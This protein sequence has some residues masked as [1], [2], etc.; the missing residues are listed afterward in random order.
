VS[1]SESALDLHDVLLGAFDTRAKTAL[2][3]QAVYEVTDGSMEVRDGGGGAQLGLGDRRPSPS[4]PASSGALV[5]RTSSRIDFRTSMV[6][7]V[8]LMVSFQGV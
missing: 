4:R 7:S 2:A 6:R 8:G 3:A 5:P 1:H